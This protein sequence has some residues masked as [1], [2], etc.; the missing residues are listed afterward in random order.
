[1]G[2]GG[3]V[4]CDWLIELASLKIRAPPLVQSPLCSNEPGSVLEPQKTA[5]TFINE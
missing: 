1:M 3:N 2:G 5:G 4:A